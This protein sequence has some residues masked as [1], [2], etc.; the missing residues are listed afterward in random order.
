MNGLA[1]TRSL[2]VTAMAVVASVM[3]EISQD[4]AYSSI[5]ALTFPTHPTLI[6][7][8]SASRPSAIRDVDYANRTTSVPLLPPTG[9]RSLSSV[10]FSP[11]TFVTAYCDRVEED[12][13]FT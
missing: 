3:M 11:C 7:S 2:T 6:L 9:N 5:H 8:G 12:Q 1:S 13:G 4:D 10:V